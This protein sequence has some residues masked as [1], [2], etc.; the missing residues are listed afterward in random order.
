MLNKDVFKTR[1]FRIWTIS[2]LIVVVSVSTVFVVHLARSD[3]ARFV[4]VSFV[5]TNEPVISNFTIDTP[6]IRIEVSNTMS[7]N[8]N[9]WV[10]AEI[11]HTATRGTNRMDYWVEAE[12]IEESS[13][14]R[15]T[16]ILDSPWIHRAI[17]SVPAHSQRSKFLLDPVLFEP[18]NAMRLHVVYERQ[19]NP[20]EISMLNKL[21][22]FKQ[23]Y[24]FQLRRSS[25]VYEWHKPETD[26]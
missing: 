11:L 24:P 14:Q 15:V 6:G 17:Y 8:V 3:S 2:A 25:P 16:A 9:Y 7:L 20:I 12:I 26:K 4:S 19:L 23:H 5:P 21:P 13:Q 18:S 10:E 22:W 1:R